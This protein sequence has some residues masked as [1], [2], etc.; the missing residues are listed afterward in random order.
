MELKTS[1]RH[2]LQ[3]YQPLSWLEHSLVSTRPFVPSDQGQ[4]WTYRRELPQLDAGGQE[5][6]RR[7]AVHA[8]PLAVDDLA[9][10]DLDD[11]DAAGEAGAGVAVEHAAVADALAAGLEQG[12]LLGVQAEAGGEGGAAGEVAGVAARAAAVHAVGQAPRRAVV[13]GGDD[14]ALAVD[15]NAADGALHAVAPPRGER[16]ERHEVAV[17]PRAQAVAVREIELAERRVQVREGVGGV[18]EPDGGPRHEREDA[19][20]SVVE[21]RV[22]LGDEGL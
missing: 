1:F 21:V 12:V 11:L 15:E 20:L 4:A 19:G 7:L 8:V 3:L 13:A 10:A 14:A 9:D 6:A 22:G 16:R 17:P 18:E 2:P 5:D